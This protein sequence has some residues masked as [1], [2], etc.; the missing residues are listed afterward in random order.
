MTKVFCDRCKQEDAVIDY[1][2]PAS[3]TNT[4]PRMIQL[5]HFCASAISAAIRDINWDEFDKDAKSSSF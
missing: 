2:L 1:I 5:C 4:A 3:P